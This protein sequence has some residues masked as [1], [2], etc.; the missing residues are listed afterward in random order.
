MS[1][2]LAVDDDLFILELYKTILTEAGYEVETA[3]DAM[4]SVTKFQEFKP[5]LLILDVEMPAGGGEKVFDR[6]RNLFMVTI[7]I[8]FSTGIPESV[9]CYAGRDNVTILK[10]PVNKET[11]LNEIKRLLKPKETPSI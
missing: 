1:K 2:I 4:S 3:E 8:I 6:L 11:L 9:E 7:P 10:K 5:D